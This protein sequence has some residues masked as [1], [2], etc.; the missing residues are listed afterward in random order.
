MAKTKKTIPDITATK[1][2]ELEQKNLVLQDKLKPFF[3]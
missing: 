2:Q 3:S 1:I